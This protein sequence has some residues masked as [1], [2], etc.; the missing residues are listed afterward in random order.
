[1]T[2]ATRKSHGFTLIELL[3]VIA[4]IAILAAI[5]F[6]VFAQAREKARATSDLSN[7][8]QIGLAELQYAQDQSEYTSGAW[9]DRTGNN[10]REH[11]GELIWPYTKSLGL[12]RDPDMQSHETNDNMCGNIYNPD[13]CPKTGPQGVDYAMNC[14]ITGD[15]SQYPG[16]PNLGSGGWGD[17]DPANLATV[18]NPAETIYITDGR[19]QDNNWDG[20]YT[21]VPAGTYYGVHWSGPNQCNWGCQAGPGHMEFDERHTNGCNVLFYDGHVKLMQSSVKKTSTYPNGSP[22]YWLLGK[23]QN[24]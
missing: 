1:L 22:Y 24:P 16:P 3:V 18:T 8:K 13:L 5:L 12:Y 20:T 11:W 10:D 17:G 21:D 7:L 2:L 23:P 4:I 15:E 9:I 19:M 14:I 6:P